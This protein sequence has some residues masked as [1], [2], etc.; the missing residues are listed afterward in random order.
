ML[1]KFA[2]TNYRGFEQKIEWDLTKARDYAFNSFAINNKTV[3]NGIIYGPNGSGKSN[4]GLAIFDIVNHLSQKWKKP[5]Y[6]VN[7]AY[8]GNQKSNVNF[9]YTFKFDDIILQYFYAKNSQGVLVSEKLIEDSN[10]VFDKDVGSFYIDEKTFPM[11]NKI[12]DSLANNANNVS[13]LNFLITTYPLREDSSLLKLQ[14]FANSMLWFRSLEE[15][16]FIGLQSNVYIID[17]YIIKN[18]LIKDFS[19]F[20]NEVS[21]QKFEFAPP[22]PDA[23][24]LICYIKGKPVLFNLVAST[25]TH[26]LTLLYFWYKQME[27]A[28]FVFIDEFDAFYH[29]KLSQN[30][31]RKLFNLKCQLFLTSHNTLLLCNDLL[32]PDCNFL[33]DKN[34]IRALHDCT[35]KELREGHNIEKLYRGG[36]FSV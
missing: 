18:N 16:E 11:D 36:T 27:N 25:G 7:F 22:A 2:V 31:C 1:C 20:L 21:E 24:Q 13:I 3:K 12:Q 32:R 10:V 15:R 35:E 33:L 8:A 5:D 6:Y 34:E 28:S 30:I 4:F 29:F 9:E 19:K 14:K 17:E 23:K 26:S